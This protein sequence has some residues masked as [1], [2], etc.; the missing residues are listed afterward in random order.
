MHYKFLFIKQVKPHFTYF[1][2][3]WQTV[4]HCT[5]S[6]HKTKPLTNKHNQMNIRHTSII[7]TPSISLIFKYSLFVSHQD[8]LRTEQAVFGNHQAVFIIRDAHTILQYD[9][10]KHLRFIFHPIYHYLIC[11]QTMRF[12]KNTKKIPQSIQMLLGEAVLFFIFQS[13]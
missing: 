9:K 10:N 12:R 5:L 7:K 13:I 8:V 4:Y 3:E 11:C 1:S 2:R 6:L